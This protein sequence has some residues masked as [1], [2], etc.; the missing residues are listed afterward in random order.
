MLSIFVLAGVYDP[1]GFRCRY[2]RFTVPVMYRL[3][4]ASATM[5]CPYVTEL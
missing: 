3:L 5:P 2:N 4:A 1:S